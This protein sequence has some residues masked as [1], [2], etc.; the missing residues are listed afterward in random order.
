MSKEPHDALTLCFLKYLASLRGVAVAGPAG[1]VRI[2]RGG[3]VREVATI[4]QKTH[5]LPSDLMMHLP[6]VLS[7]IWPP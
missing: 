5:V 2:K 4:H 3:S 1:S 7:S 6:C